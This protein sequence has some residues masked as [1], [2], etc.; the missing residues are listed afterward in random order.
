[1]TQGIEML[2]PAATQSTRRPDPAS[3]H[4]AGP[5]TGMARRARRR[6]SLAAGL[7]AGVALA[8]AA[9][10]GALALSL[11]TRGTSSAR[12]SAAPTFAEAGGAESAGPGEALFTSSAR[13]RTQEVPEDPGGWSALA[14]V[15]LEEGRATADP[16]RY[17]EAEAAVVRSLR[18]QPEGNDLALAARAGIANA[19]HDFAAARLDAERALSIN[20]YSATALAALTDALTEL[21]RL[22]EA[23]AAARR[24]DENQP[25]AGSFA[26]LSYQAELRGDLTGAADLMR[27]A[28][29]LADTP[30]QAAFARYHE[31][32][33]A[34]ADGDVEAARTALAA[35]AS[36]ASGDVLLLH[37][38][39]RIAVAEEAPG[40]AE[41]LY[42]RLV[43][44]RPTPVY[45]TEQAEVLL[46]A[47]DDEGA[48][49]ALDVAR[50]GYA[51]QT[52]ADVA[53]EGTQ[54]LFEAEHGDPAGAV[55]LGR[56]VLQ[57]SPTAANADAL[58]WA[59]HRAGE[60][61]EALA[62]ADR[63]LA[64]GARPASVLYHRG[65]VR[66]ALGDR[67]GAV[68]DLTEAL[69]TQPRFSPVD[70]ARARDL[71]ASIQPTTAQQGGPS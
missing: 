40:S 16:A 58:A 65:A 48:R 15:A 46:G 51:L 11:S 30:A 42:E 18:L 55:R 44:R 6:R 7:A 17:A 20:P 3:D 29:D 62:L 50:A 57:R 41:R 4:V 9:G 53:A 19:R 43:A 70:A 13:R 49:A 10:V 54:V 35:G 31:G 36:V 28:A 23:L 56:Q 25:G 66:A 33:L 71:L 45:A 47:G 27:R 52:S 21:G 12:S 22:D 68:A 1:M 63:A 34:L 69:R 60:S 8:V 37:L 5:Q 38:S 32:L 67:E 24:L 59:L 2:P 26:R 64:V 61:R 14:L 39:A